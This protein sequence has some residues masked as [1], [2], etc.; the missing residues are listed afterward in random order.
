MLKNNLGFR[1]K[2]RSRDFL[3]SIINSLGGNGIYNIRGNHSKKDKRALVIYTLEAV[4]KHLSNT[5]HRSPSLTSHSGFNESISLLNC[6]LDA[7]YTVDYFHFVNTPKIEWS[8]YELVIDAFKNLQYSKQVIGQ[9]KIFYST[10]CHWKTFY[11]NAYMHSESFFERNGILL[12]PDRELITNYSDNT[13]DIITCFGGKYQAESFGSNHLKVKQLNI[14]TTFIPSYNFKKQIASKTKFLWYGGHGPFHKGL[15]LV[16]EAFLKMP[17]FELHIFGNIELNNE[18][19]LWFQ[20]KLNTSKNIIYHGWSTPE[21]MYFQSYVRLCDSFV[22]ASSSEGGAGSV[23]QCMQFG[24][25]PIINNSTA[26]DLDNNKF[27]IEGINPKD[28][29]NSIIEKAELFSRTEN[30]ELEI[31]TE[32]LYNKYSTLNTIE[33]YELSLNSIIQEL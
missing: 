26:V 10:C 18:L 19:F 17:N 5:L 7:G 3:N 32:F 24:L 23:I 21:S 4:S 9:K 1:L 16:V 8:K 28:Q 14:S 31:Y 13:S 6:L 27:D 2:Y 30:Q 22:F 12:Y 20:K 33:M 11:E 15:D 25:I 29:I